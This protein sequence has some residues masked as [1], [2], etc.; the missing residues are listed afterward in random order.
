MIFSLSFNY[1]V[2]CCCFSL[3]LDFLRSLFSVWTQAALPI[4][5][6]QLFVGLITCFLPLLPLTSFLPR[7]SLSSVLNKW[8]TGFSPSPLHQL[9]LKAIPDLGHPTT[10][11]PIKS[12][13]FSFLLCPPEL[14]SVKQNAEPVRVG[15]RSLLMW[16]IQSQS[17]VPVLIANIKWFLNF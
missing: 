8:F 11:F 17:T 14:L 16:E 1:H 5:R 12:V 6:A 9:L 2:V 3:I 13:I 4:E 10:S 15:L 7:P